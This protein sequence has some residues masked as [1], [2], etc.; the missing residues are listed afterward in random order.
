MAPPGGLCPDCWPLVRF[1]GPSLCNH[2][3]IPIS[4]G[5]QDLCD[6]CPTNPPAYNKARSALVY[7]DGS[8]DLLLRLKHADA[9]AG[10]PVMARWMLRAG[11]DILKDTDWLVPVPLHRVRL[12]H[13][14]YNQSAELA[15]AVARLSGV[16]A[17]PDGLQRIRNTPSQGGLSRD[18]R[19]A[20][21]Q[22][23]FRTTPGHRTR[24]LGARVTLI[25]DVMTT[26]ATIN[27]CANALIAAGATRVDAVCLARVE[28]SDSWHLTNAAHIP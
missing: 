9:L 13:R 28:Q 25:D 10:V 11:A 22:A 3:G 18:K 6:E 14:R 2:C 24:L 26:G 17:L 5:P 19:K 7:D 4:L 23:A 16:K 15:R 20:N 8:R 27:A 1:L 21:L 12:F